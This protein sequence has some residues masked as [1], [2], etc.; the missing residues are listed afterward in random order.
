MHASRMPTD[1]SHPSLMRSAICV[2]DVGDVPLHLLEPVLCQCSAPQLA[3]IE[4]ET[5]CDLAYLPT[6]P[7]PSAGPLP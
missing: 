2:G 5:R 1:Y 7:Q 4:D 3:A 6:D